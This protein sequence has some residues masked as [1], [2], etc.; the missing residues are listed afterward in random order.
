MPN[1]S[2]A[3]R[4]VCIAFQ[5][6]PEESPTSESAETLV[7]TPRDMSPLDGEYEIGVAGTASGNIDISD[8]LSDALP[9]YLGVVWAC[10][11]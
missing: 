3:A 4:K 5:V 2:N 7:H 1:G 6:V 9:I 11:C 8:K 10:P